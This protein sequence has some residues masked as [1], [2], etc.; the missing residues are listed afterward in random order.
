MT[1]T[2]GHTTNPTDPA[3]PQHQWRQTHQTINQILSFPR[4]LPVG[5]GVDAARI[6][7][8]DNECV[9]TLRTPVAEAAQPKK[10]P[11]VTGSSSRA[12]DGSSTDEESSN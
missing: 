10:I 1:I 2:P 7:A 3:R 9:L 8:R 4:D 5:D 12:I 11:V 6:E